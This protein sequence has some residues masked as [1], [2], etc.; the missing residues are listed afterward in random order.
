M[1]YR[2]KIINKNLLVAIGPEYAYLGGYFGR[3]AE[4]GCEIMVPAPGFP[5]FQGQLP[6]FQ[7]R[8][9]ADPGKV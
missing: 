4:W 7:G 8:F 9:Q 5:T 3:Q 6:N 2:N 1:T